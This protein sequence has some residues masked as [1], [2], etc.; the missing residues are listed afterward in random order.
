MIRLP[1]ERVDERQQIARRRNAR[2]G[3]DR[4]RLRKQRTR[5]SDLSGAL[6]VDQ[7]ARKPGMQWKPLNPASQCSHMKGAVRPVDG[8]EPAQQPQRRR[9]AIR[10]RRFEPFER[11]RVRPPG[12]EIEQRRR[13]IDARHFRF[14]MGAQPVSRIPQPPD[15]SR[16]QARGA[17][18][19][20]IGRILRHALQRQAVHTA[21]GIVA[22]HF[23]LTG[24]DHGGHSRHGERR[25]RDVRGKDDPAPIGGADRGVLRIAVEGSVQRNHLDTVGRR[26]GRQF[27]ARPFDFTSAR[28]KAE[29]LPSR[30][31]QH[32]CDRFQHRFAGRI[33]GGER[34]KGA[35]HIHHGAIT[36]KRR[37][38]V[39]VQ[40]GGHH[41][42]AKI[43]AG[44][45]GLASQ[46][47]AH[48]RVDA[49]L[50]KFVEYHGGEAR[51]QRVLLQA[52]CEDAFSDHQEPRVL[53][54]PAFEP[55]LPADFAAQRPVAFFR[56]ASR[57]RPGGDAARLQQQHGARIHERGRDAR[58]LTG[59]RRGYQHHRAAPC[60]LRAHFFDV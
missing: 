41:E 60:Q 38:G 12:E 57:H 39:G 55:Y 8:T 33:F 19:A 13:E 21:L 11:A 14:A 9:Q 37:D 46:R 51:E 28:Q 56:D 32:T 40:R 45:P 53:S 26:R 42:E 23:H 48:V 43:I 17:P 49:P 59:A 58:G 36:E 54:E 7:D 27:S 4:Q 22:R 35:R 44:E 5:G 52:R 1:I 10:I 3:G 24:V 31:W 30:S 2:T 20:L 34:M 6:S 16:P 15:Q 25:F 47:Q 50:V 18:G 29:K